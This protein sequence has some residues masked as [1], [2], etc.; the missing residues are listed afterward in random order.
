MK[1]EL[2]VVKI[3]W[4]NVLFNKLFY[5]YCFKELFSIDF[6]KEAIKDKDSWIVSVAMSS[7]LVYS[8]IY[9]INGVQFLLMLF[10]VAFFSALYATYDLYKYLTSHHQQCTQLCNI[11]RK[12]NFKRTIQLVINNIFDKNYE[13]NNKQDIEILEKLKQ[14]EKEQT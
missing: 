9:N 12:S 2:S 4:Y 10:T 13:S 1:C 3:M 6:Y 14:F 7:V 5:K 8:I 11:V